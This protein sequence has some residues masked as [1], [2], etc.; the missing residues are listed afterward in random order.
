[1]RG[2]DVSM[3]TAQRRHRAKILASLVKARESKR[4][5]RIARARQET[6]K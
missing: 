1:M 6:G 2:E 4:Q 5:K 3:K